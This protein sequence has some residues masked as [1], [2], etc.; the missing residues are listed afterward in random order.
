MSSCGIIPTTIPPRSFAPRQAPSIT[1]PSPPVTVTPPLVAI[2]LPT[3]L[4]A[5][6]VLAAQWS[7]SDPITKTWINRLKLDCAVRDKTP[8]NKL[9]PHKIPT[10]IAS[11]VLEDN[12][13]NVTADWTEKVLM[14]NRVSTVQIFRETNGFRSCQ[15]SNRGGSS[16]LLAPS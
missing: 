8:L 5:S 4:A 2:C 14:R 1:P 10:E 6:Y 16:E 13:A 15:A 9:I 11:I 3:S 7:P 12:E